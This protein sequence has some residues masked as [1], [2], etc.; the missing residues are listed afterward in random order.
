MIIFDGH[1][2]LTRQRFERHINLAY[3]MPNIF[4]VFNTSAINSPI[5][6]HLDELFG[7]F[8]H[9]NHRKLLIIRSFINSQY[10][11]Q[12]IDEISILLRRNDPPFNPPGLQFIFF[13]VVATLVCDRLSTTCNSTSR[14]AIA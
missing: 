6:N 9:T 2:T 4:G 8:I 7:G 3:P 13:S 11:F 14:S 5:L 10:L 1:K 12:M